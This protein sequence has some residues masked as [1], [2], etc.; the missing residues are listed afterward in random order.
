MKTNIQYSI[1]KDIDLDDDDEYIQ[2]QAK[3]AK[4]E[5]QILAYKDTITDLD[6][7]QTDVTSTKQ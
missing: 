2:L 1:A 4:T 5:K 6:T 3:I 7:T